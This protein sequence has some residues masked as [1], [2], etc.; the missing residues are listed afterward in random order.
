VVETR[1]RVVAA[2]L[3]LF[4]EEG[5]EATTMRRIAAEAG[6]SLGNAYHYFG[7]KDD[8]VRELYLVVQR[9]HRELAGPR[10][11]RGGSLT[12][13]LRVALHAGLDVL[14]PYHGFGGAFLAVALPPA[15][16]HSPFSADST[17]VREQAVGLMRDVVGASRGRPTGPLA[18]RLPT[19]LWLL[20][21]GVTL[22]WV[23]D[24]TP[25]QQR[26]RRLVDATAPIVTRL[27]G[28]ARLPGG[29]RLVTD[30]GRVMDLVAEPTPVPD[31]PGEP[32]GAPEGRT[33]ER[34]GR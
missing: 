34:V 8:L 20:Y 16:R 32:A 22:H 28:L 7:G 4:R 26:T 24:P 27:V 29:R 11:R 3:R 5:F 2:A 14:G 31:P 30:V 17:A 21:L 33:S 23:T 6:V 19:L 9:E 12:G 25:D 13:N 15:S 1:E 10:L 18:D